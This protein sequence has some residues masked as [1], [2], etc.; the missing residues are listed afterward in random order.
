MSTSTRD[1]AQQALT[2]RSVRLAA[3]A[4][5]TAAGV[6]VA[7]A[8]W[9]RRSRRSEPPSRAYRL[10][11]EE[12]P[13]EGMRR[14]AIG[15]TEK[16]I[17]RLRKGQGGGDPVKCVH[18]A[19]K[20]LKKAR[21]V[22]RLLR[23]ELGEERYRAENDAYREAGRLLSDSRDAAVKV[24]TLEGICERYA[25]R[26]PGG[27]AE[28]WL[29]V[30]REERDRAVQSFEYGDPA[31]EEAL[32]AIERGREKID[33][34]PLEGEGWKLVGPGVARA[35]RRG[36]KRMRRVAEDPSPEAVH[37]WRKRVKD[38]WYHLRILEPA[39]P[40]ELADRVEVADRLADV[41]GEHHDLAVLRD[42]L[43][44]RDLPTV[45]RGAL[46]AAMSDRQEELVAEALPLG[47]RL[48]AEK[49]KRFRKKMRTGWRSRRKP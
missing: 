44:F 45:K 41:L 5:A 3:V 23:H 37:E 32:G 10:R 16:A 8:L 40:G 27:A 38:L 12:S 31:L 2:G 33:A 21:A 47:E 46:V 17:G 11:P 22:L 29:Q 42:D 15:R 26:V 24:Q 39:T 7:K 4:V 13:E 20:D 30:L 35:Y 25:G 43:L 28:E 18:G 48:Y 6:A 1:L 36:R 49:P 14:I 9:A 34:W 19:R